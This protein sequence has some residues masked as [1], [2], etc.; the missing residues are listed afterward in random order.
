MSRLLTWLKNWANA[1]DDRFSRDRHKLL[2]AMEILEPRQM[3]A[4]N[5]FVVFDVLDVS[6]QVHWNVDDSMLFSS[7]WQGDGSVAGAESEASMERDGREFVYLGELADE[8]GDLFEI[9]DE[10]HWWLNPE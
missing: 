7:F 4:A 1:G 8:V 10:E 9:E 5:S 2:P 3:L 6:E